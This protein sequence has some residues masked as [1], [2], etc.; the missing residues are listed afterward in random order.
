[1]TEAGE[2]IQDLAAWDQASLVEQDALL[3]QLS[4]SGCELVGAFMGR[5]AGLRHRVGV[6][7][8]QATGMLLHLIPGGAYRLGQEP[9]LDREAAPRSVELAPFLIGRFPVRQEE[10][11]RLGG[12]DRRPLRD[13]DLPICGVS[14]QA[15]EAWLARAGL[16]LPS[17]D[18]WE[19]ACRAG[20]LTPWFF[21][22]EFQSAYA[23][24][25]DN[26]DRMPQAVSQ[27]L[28]RANAFGLVDMAGNVSEWCQERLDAP[29]EGSAWNEWDP[30]RVHRGGSFDYPARACRSAFRGGTDP[31]R[32]Y[33]DLGV[34][35][36]LSL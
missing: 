27:H 34:R 30:G 9:A 11:D 12:Q 32:D 4:P 21:G 15:A 31:G 16:R 22:A 33:P 8:H 2:L 35:A 19:A 3:R 24:V 26:S 36:A 25:H 5:C 14:C 1:V 18:E 13:P 6:F 17:E 10:W 28:S 29:M 20:S 23:W 7:R